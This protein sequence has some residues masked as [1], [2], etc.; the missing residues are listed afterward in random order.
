[1]EEV[2]LS[3]GLRSLRQ[4]L[5]QIKALLAWEDLKQ[6][7]AKSS[8]LSAFRSTDSI[9]ADLRN[10]YSYFLFTSVQI[11]ELLNDCTALAI[12]EEKRQFLK[13]QLLNLDKQLRSLDLP[14][15]FYPIQP[16]T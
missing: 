7:E 9:E 4:S 12:P 2:N 5:R 15:R 16:P 14:A 3:A 8:S 1:M 13:R 6:A 10:E 11:H